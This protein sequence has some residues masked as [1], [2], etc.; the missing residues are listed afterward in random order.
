MTNSVVA[1]CSRVIVVA[2]LSVVLVVDRGARSVRQDRAS[3]LSQ[4]S[5]RS[6]LRAL[7][8]RHLN[9][10]LQEDPQ[11][12]RKCKF[13]CWSSPNLPHPRRPPNQQA[14]LPAA[15]LLERSL[16]T[17]RRPFPALQTMRTSS[18]NCKVTCPSIFSL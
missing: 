3:M 4:Y 10:G 16:M 15:S 12:S 17:F 8:E 6:F 2:A 13:K 18:V 5:V 14:R 1:R 11:H 7:S 9:L